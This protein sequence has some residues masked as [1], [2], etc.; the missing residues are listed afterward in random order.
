MKHIGMTWLLGASLLLATFAGVR[1]NPIY[2]WNE[3]LIDSFRAA[4]V[5]V[6]LAAVD[7]AMVNIAMYDAVNAVSG[8]PYK[9]YL[10][11]SGVIPAAGSS[12]DAAAFWAGYTVINN[13]FQNASASVQTI[14]DNTFTSGLASLGSGKAIDQGKRVGVT[15]ATNWLTSRA[16]DSRQQAITGTWN[17]CATLN[18]WQPTPP[19]FTGPLVPGF[20]DVN[21]FVV[22][23]ST[24]FEPGAPPAPGSPTW[25]AD[26]NRTMCLGQDLSPT[27]P[28]ECNPADPSMNRTVTQTQM[29][30]N[31]SDMGGTMTPPGR[32]LD[33]ADQLIASQALDTLQ[34]ARLSA[35]LGAAL[36]DSAITIWQ[37]KYD[38][39][40]IRPVTVANDCALAAAAGVVCHPGWRPLLITTP[41][42]PEYPSG[43][44][45]FGGA[46]SVI[47]QN[48]FGTDLMNFEIMPD[49]GAM[50]T[51]MAPVCKSNSNLCDPIE[52]TSFSQLAIDDAASRVYGGVHFEFSDNQ[53][54]RT[55]EQIAQYVFATA[56]NP[57][58][59][60]SSRMLLAAGLGIF[61][62]VR[63]WRWRRHAI[64]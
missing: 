55:G 61:T 24:Q 20:G 19:D 33:I 53:G 26:Y 40:T 62:V 56:M 23:S 22:T 45:T 60:P 44:A 2:N 49:P 46:G 32:L 39:D 50:A 57:I 21:P 27:R 43:H 1:A 48:F 14:I 13:L 64:C 4:G 37:T 10:T 30:I 31:W 5:N 6:P 58:P 47:F 42:F 11:Y 16:G 34:S 41:N 29:A 59:E 36:A 51:Y 25:I 54:M 17:G 9:P 18:C 52:Y 15:Q 63:R 38:Y 12:A 35:L 3:T 28:A 7:V 8:T